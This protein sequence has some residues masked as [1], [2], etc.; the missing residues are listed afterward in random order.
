MEVVLE[1]F[2][3]RLD[4]IWDISEDIVDLV[5]TK[6]FGKV[7]EDDKIRVASEL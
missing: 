7:G 2:V 6:L 4:V 5:A 3:G 1:V